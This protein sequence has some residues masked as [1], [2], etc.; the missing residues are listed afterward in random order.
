MFKKHGVLFAALFSLLLV[1]ATFAQPTGGPYG[2]VQ[3]NYQLPEIAGTI[4]YVAPDGEPNASGTSLAEPTSLDN[5]ITKVVTGDAIILR[6]GVYRTGDLELNQSILMQPYK[7]EQPVI[8]GTY[9]ADKWETVAEPTSE[10]PGLW[11]I[12]W[13]RLFRSA[14]DDW[15]RTERAGRQTP[16]HKFN[17]DMVF[18]DGR[19][20]Q[21]AGWLNE[22]TE[23]NFY[24]DYENEYVYISTDPRNRTVEITAFDQG[25]VITARDVNGKKADHQGPTIRGIHFS[26][27]AFHVIDVEG[28]YPNKKSSEDEHGKDV[29]GTTFENCTISYGG[30]V[31]AFVLGDKFTMKNCKITDTSTE[32]LY[33]VSSADVLLENNIFTKNNIENI[34]GYYPAAVKIFNQTHRVVCN[35]NLVIDLPNSNGIWYDVGNRDGVFTNNWLEGIGNNDVPFT[36]ESVWPSRN[37]FFFEISEGVRVAG[38]V[39]V[40]NDHGILI[41]NAK[42]AKV[43]NNTFVNSMAVFGRDRRGEQVDHFGWHVTTGPD[44]HDRVDHEFVNNLMV[45]GPEFERPLLYIWQRD[46]MCDDYTEEPMSEL[47]NNAYVKLNENDSPA[48][49]R[50]G[51]VKGACI[52]SF[53]T[54]ADMNTLFSEFGKN[55]TTFVN[56]Q[57]PLFKS[58]HL[59]NFQ[60][61]KGFTGLESASTIPGFIKSVIRAGTPKKY[62]G[63]YP[64]TK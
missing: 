56:Y 49:W 7:S 64:I 52:S 32:G 1:S 28:Y 60:L 9:L 36:G 10:Q 33:V 15:W 54:A 53:S 42:G 19:F 44:V 50:A 3:K 48:I 6:G 61:L 31:G 20:L 30:R 14:P 40:N 16:L 23:D 37:A 26:Q 12:K 45:A 17:D 34:T 4:Y 43:Y 21:S 29:V 13:D 8:K 39:F 38:N 2:P 27:Y 51:K 47:D 62:L 35:N 55:S 63:A 22:L 57:G 11:K 58:M 25:L 46:N 41:L 24:I 5:A 59:E 18:V